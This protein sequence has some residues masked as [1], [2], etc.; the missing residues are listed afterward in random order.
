VC[1]QGVL[2]SEFVVLE[3]FTGIEPESKG[4]ELF[5]TVKFVERTEATMSKVAFLCWVSLSMAVTE[6]IS[7]CLS[8]S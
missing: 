6:E 1:L 7:S 4:K 3:A 2:E 5:K 8:E